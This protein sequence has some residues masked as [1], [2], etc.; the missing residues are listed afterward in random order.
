LCN[1]SFLLTNVSLFTALKIPGNAW[2]L[3]SAYQPV[4]R[5]QNKDYK[6]KGT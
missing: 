2:W 3:C 1:S 4:R 6:H 5:W